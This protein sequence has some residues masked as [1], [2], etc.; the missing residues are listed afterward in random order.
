MLSGISAPSL[1]DA[2]DRMLLR[3]SRRDV[4]IRDAG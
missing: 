4:C 2:I 3:G 1:N